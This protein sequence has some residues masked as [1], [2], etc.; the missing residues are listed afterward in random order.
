MSQTAS[1]GSIDEHDAFLDII[2]TQPIVLTGGRSLSFSCWASRAAPPP[3]WPI[4]RWRIPAI[5]PASKIDR[6]C[7]ECRALRDMTGAKHALRLSLSRL[8]KYRG[9]VLVQA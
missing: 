8:W 4:N 5:R 6:G 9:L 2:W 7:L 3:A 1:H